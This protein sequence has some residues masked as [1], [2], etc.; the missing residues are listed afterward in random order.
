MSRRFL[1]LSLPA[2]ATL[3]LCLSPT[4]AQRSNSAP[5]ARIPGL[6]DVSPA[7]RSEVISAPATVKVGEA[8]VITVT[9]SGGGCERPGDA[10]VVLGENEAN[11]MVYDVTVATR[12]NVAC[13]MIYKRMPHTATL[14]FT[15]PGE[16]V[17]RVWGRRVGAE[18]PHFGVPAVIDQKITVK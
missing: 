3:V 9:T 11:V 2:A 16:A 14:R 18:T 1:V 7:A 8:F 10:S 12:P 6:I 15:K 5:E 17:I 4:A 13:T